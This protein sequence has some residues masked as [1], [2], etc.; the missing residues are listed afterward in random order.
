MDDTLTKIK[1][2]VYDKCEFELSKFI[3]EKEGKQYGACRFELDG[4]SIISRNAKTTPKKVGQFVTFWKRMDN[5]PIEPYSDADHIDFY[6]VNVRTEDRFGQFVFPK[7][8]LIKRGII[9]T[10]K[11]E[12]KRAFRVYPNWDVT[13]NKQ[14]VQTQKWQQNHFYEI[15]N[16]LDINAVVQLFDQGRK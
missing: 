7:S 14:A 8:V 4:L 10:Y 5:G 13:S 9:S 1:M 15:N 6:V 12:G 3:V 2:R 11:K 16:S